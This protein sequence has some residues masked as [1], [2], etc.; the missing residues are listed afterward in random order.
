MAEERISYFNGDF[1]PDSQCVIHI[2][3]RGFLRGDTV[4]D[5]ARSFDGK[6]HRVR[7]HLERLYRSM[8]FARI[9]PGMTMDEMEAITLDVVKRN[10]HLREPGGDFVIWQTITRGYA[11]TFAK[12]NDPA[13]SNVCISVLPIDFAAHAEHYKSGGHVVFPRT[14]SYAPQ[15]LEPKLKHYS[16]MNFSMAE[17]EATDVDPDA[18][19]VLLD[20]D[21]NI[22][23]NVSGNFFVVTNGVIR[24]PTD[25]SIL[26]GVARMDVF[27]LAEQLG[28]PVVEEDLQPYDAYT[29]DEAFLSN[30]IY[31]VL[32][33]G[34]IDNREVRG[35][36]PGPITQRLWAAWSEKVGLDIV[37]QALSYAAAKGRS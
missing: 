6:P 23:E 33:V 3:D 21:G 4:F 18:Y 1:V 36:V 20:T 32:P 8:A 10:E 28:I 14:R 17:L 9:D 16:R 19:T 27:D 37:D 2:S 13:P 7:E 30:T 29:A 15:S 12:V 5:V 22:A 34:R 24:T 35:D 31:C 11:N 25:R 26:Q